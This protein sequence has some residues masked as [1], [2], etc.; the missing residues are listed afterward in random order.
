[1]KK[2]SVLIGTT[3]LAA[4]AGLPNRGVQPEMKPIEKYAGEKSFAAEVGQWPSDSWWAQYGDAQLNALVDE[5][6]AG[7]PSLAA[8]DARVRRA[9]A[10]ADGANAARLPQASINSSASE[11][12]QSYN[13]LSPV[14]FTPHGWKDYGRATFDL[15]WELDFWGKNR[16]AYAA[17]TSDAAAVQ[18]DAAQARIALAAS[19][20]S[21]YAELA[22]EYSALDTAQAAL[23][24]RRK[25][26]ELFRTR[27]QNGLETIGSVRQVESRRAAAEADVLALQEQ[28]ALQRNR[29]AALLGAGPDRGL[30]IERPTLNF[31]RVFALPAQL[32]A[33][34]IGRRPDL[35]AARFRAEAASKRIHQAQAAFYPNV[36]LMG[37]IGAQ[38]LGLDMLNKNGSSISSV[39]PAISLPIFTGGRLRAQLHSAD[40]DYAEAVANYDR[41]VVQALQEVADAVVSKKAL[42]P[43][44][45]R[46]DDAVSAAREAWRVQNNRYEGGLAAYLDVLSAEDY[47]L[48]NLRTQADLQSRS[49][50]LDVA[51]VRALGGGYSHPF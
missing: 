44:L 39:G 47:L 16:A 37:F 48:S 32:A 45:A 9:L 1:M 14:A 40:A 36:N 4:C 22:R 15:S 18:A 12:K 8:A 50:T 38:S 19:I 11:Q 13:Y 29:V 17:A 10:V 23:D 46:I 35:T 42:A 21:A 27:F 7:S 2:L 31:T 33:N 25:T 43:Q 26:A 6:L 28:I 34:L 41:T 30:T 51:L 24:V 3:L 49:F 20:A 5:A